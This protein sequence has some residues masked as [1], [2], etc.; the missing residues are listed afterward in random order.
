ME[1]EYTTSTGIAVKVRAANPYLVGRVEGDV[2]AEWQAAGKA[3]PSVPTYT[4]E[5]ASGEKEVHEHTPS[6]LD[7]DEEKAAWQ[8]YE[9]VQLAYYREIRLRQTRI[10]LAK[11]VIFEMP[12]DDAWVEAQTFLGIH[13]PEAGE[14]RRLHYLET[15]VI[16]CMADVDML[17]ELAQL[18]SG[19]TK[20]AIDA[21]EKSVPAGAEGAPA[22]GAGDEPGPVGG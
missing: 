3:L 17:W 8:R 1:L 9:Q 5:T 10:M 11:C 4:V 13:V 2:Q 14:A 18:A 19:V 7:T 22:R 20:A 21:A 6:T 12:A 15:E 16:G